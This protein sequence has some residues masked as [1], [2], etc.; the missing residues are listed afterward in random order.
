MEEVATREV[1]ALWVM[2][3]VCLWHFMGGVRTSCVRNRACAGFVVIHPNE[4]VCDQRQTVW[5][6]SVGRWNSDLVS[7]IRIANWE[8]NFLPVE[9]ESVGCGGVFEDYWRRMKEGLHKIFPES[10]E[11]I[12]SVQNS[13]DEY[14]TEILLLFWNS[15]ARPPFSFGS[16]CGFLERASQGFTAFSKEI[17]FKQQERER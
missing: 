5:A 9:W 13:G 8:S 6:L 2:G 1:R 12:D 3:M 15:L 16:S 4:K 17:A 7:I 10:R 14:K 11:G